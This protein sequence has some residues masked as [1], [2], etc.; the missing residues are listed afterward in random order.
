[1]YSQLKLQKDLWLLS[2]VWCWFL[3][4][5]SFQKTKTKQL[6]AKV[7]CTVSEYTT[8]Q[9]AL[10]F[11]V[12]YQGCINTVVKLCECFAVV[13]FWTRPLS[14]IFNFS[15]NWSSSEVCYNYGFSLPNTLKI[16]AKFTEMSSAA[17]RSCAIFY[18]DPQF[19]SYT[20]SCVYAMGPMK[21]TISSENK[22][23]R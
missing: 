18:H 10:L 14:T 15:I 12:G 21:T 1:M 23:T 20:P 7:N 8:H 3:V 4:V 6:K 5:F 16:K 2:G 13:C 9:F 11:G 19:T 22:R 17:L